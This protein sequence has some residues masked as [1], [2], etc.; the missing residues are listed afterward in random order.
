MKN[1]LL[2]FLCISLLIPLSLSGQNAG[3]AITFETRDHDFGSIKESDGAVSFAFTFTNTGKAPLILTN[4][5]AS[6]GCTTPDWTREPVLPGKPGVIK[7]SFNPA[8]R[9]G[10]F[11]KT[12]TV[13]SNAE[14]PSV[15]LVIRGVVIPVSKMEEV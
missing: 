11:N 4:V 15:T 5:H 6:C 10:A 9:P 2:S 3:S 8:Q 1:L 7:V 13:T 14:T 12:I